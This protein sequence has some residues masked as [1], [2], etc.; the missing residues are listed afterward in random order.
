MTIQYP[1][2][3]DKSRTVYIAMDYTSGSNR[4]I[5]DTIISTLK[6]NGINNIVDDGIGPNQLYQNMKK[7]VTQNKTNAIILNVFNGVDPTNIKEVGLPNQGD[8]LEYGNDNTG[9]KSRE[10][11]ND[12]I[13]AWFYDS[14][15]FTRP[16]GTC[17][18]SI[19]T[20]SPRTD[21]PD[22][23]RWPSSEKPLDYCQRN[24]IYVVNQSSNQSNNPERRDRTGEKVGQAIADLFSSGATTTPTTTDDISE[25]ATGDT[26]KT[27]STKTIT[28]S[29]TSPH[30]ERVYKLKTDYN[31]AFSLLHTL[32]YQGEYRILMKFGGDKTHQ[33]STRS[34]T[35]QNYSTRS[36]IFKEQLLHTETT[37]KYTDNTVETQ[38]TGALPDTKYIKKVITTENYENGTL[39][40]KNTKTIYMEDILKPADKQE[41]DLSIPDMG[42]EDYIQ[43]VT[44]ANAGN[45]FNQQIPVKTDGS[46]NV[47]MMITGGKPYVNV[48]WTKSYTLTKAQYQAVMQR[49]SRTLQINNYKP[50]KYTAFE[51]T[52]TNTYNVVSRETWNLLEES[53]YHYRVFNAK[54]FPDEVTFNFQ[55][56]TTT[57]GGVTT[58]WKGNA[59]PHDYNWTGCNIHWVG[60]GQRHKKSCG[61]TSSAVCTQVLHN[62]YSER[63]LDAIVHSNGRGSG[64]SELRDALLKKGFGSSLYSTNRNTALAE[65]DAGKPTVWHFKDHY[66]CLS[67]RIPNGNVLICN[68]AGEGNGYYTQYGSSTTGW[69]G[70]SDIKGAY[71]QAVKVWCNY[72]ISSD[73]KQQLQNFLSSMG[74]SWTRPNTTEHVR[75]SSYG[76]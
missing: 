34:I 10:L 39:K 41:I 62:F 56:R 28:K 18:N 67:C 37:I 16:D 48:D 20:R 12:V 73:E 50:S 38:S 7:V 30:Y 2:P 24:K 43:N 75:K 32:P 33:S 4:K 65:L 21:V 29:Y 60:D 17:Y 42:M 22:G 55:A 59:S 27:I 72:T 49:D 1:N 71:G 9:K 54:G 3:L 25:I 11:G 63:D 64:P 61:P 40:D 57:C 52:D 74:G 66:I 5:L 53:I 26:T 35:V 6:Q 47:S 58:V 19:K 46:P 13:L 76:T 8:G 44:S 36:G 45:P 31:G 68:S 51:S 15:D 14:C 23:G 69:H 70:I